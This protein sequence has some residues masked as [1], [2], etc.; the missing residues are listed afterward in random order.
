MIV[1]FAP[2]GP[3]PGKKLKIVGCTT[4]LLVVVDEPAGVLMRMGPVL[5][6]TGT[7]RVRDELFVGNPNAAET[8]LKRTF[9][10]PRKLTPVKVTFVFAR[11]VRGENAVI[12]GATRKLELVKVPSGERTLMGPL[13]TSAGG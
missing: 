10:A 3:A 2:A 9:V 7:L 8:P 12:V 13:T 4:K 1:T 5:A 11:P 6:P